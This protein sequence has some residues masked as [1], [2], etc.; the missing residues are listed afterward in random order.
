MILKILLKIWPALT[1]ILLYLLW[2]LI[3][4]ILNK[5][6]KNY[7]DGE[8]QDIKE[9]IDKSPKSNQDNENEVGPFSLKNNVFI[10]VIYLSLVLT[11]ISFLF[12]ALQH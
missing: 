5:R 1:P 10:S 3:N 2:I 12:F 4:K 8:F 7:I 11:I 6:K 9:T